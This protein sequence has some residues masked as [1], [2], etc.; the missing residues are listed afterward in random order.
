M[1][2]EG[3]SR[4]HINLRMMVSTC[5]RGGAQLDWDPR[6][7]EV[8][9]SGISPARRQPIHP[10]A[11]AA[12]EAFPGINTRADFEQWA[13]GNMCSMLLGTEVRGTQIQRLWCAPCNR[14][15][16]GIPGYYTATTCALFTHPMYQIYR[17]YHEYIM[18]HIH[19]P[20][21][22]ASSAPFSRFRIIAEVS[23]P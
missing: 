19:V 11:R 23:W 8:M 20:N 7:S 4:Q 18:H 1:V 10:L 3:I 12:P 22:P 5:S 16:S 14:N 21:A 15:T 9:C 2:G 13:S 17:M 6:T